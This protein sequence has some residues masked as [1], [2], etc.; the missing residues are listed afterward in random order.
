MIKRII[1]I[2]RMTNKI[3]NRREYCSIDAML[4]A[5]ESWLF[6]NHK[7]EEKEEFKIIIKQEY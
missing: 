7:M 1:N 5:V 6:N 2:E 3:F 4:S